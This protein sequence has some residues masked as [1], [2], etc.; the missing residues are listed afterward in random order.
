M[1]KIIKKFR[2]SLIIIIASISL[3]VFA[4]SQSENHLKRAISAMEIGLFEESLKQLNY[5]LNDDPKNDQVHK[6]RALLYEAL[7]KKEKA[8]ESWNDCIRYSKDQNMIKEAKIH[9][10]HLNEI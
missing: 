5:A 1:K 8:I 6:L 2:P 7:E 3:S 10:N 4:Y 9:L